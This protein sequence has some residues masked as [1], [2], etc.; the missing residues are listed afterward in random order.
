VVFVQARPRPSCDGM[1]RSAVDAG[2]A[3][4]VA[5]AEQLP[6]RIIDY[7][8]HA[9]LARSPIHPGRTRPRAPWRRCLSCPDPD[10]HDFSPYKKSTIYR[11]VE[12][13]MGL[14]QIDKIANLCPVSRENP[15]EMSCLSKELLIGVT[16]FFPRL[17]P[18][19][20]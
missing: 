12:R 14:A 11:R 7:L 15:Q 1:P 4:V 9:P 18:G 8:K 10:R 13:R 6:G 19:S 2:L 3:D 5:P 17:P 20:N 16:V